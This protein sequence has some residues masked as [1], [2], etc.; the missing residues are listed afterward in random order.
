MAHWK[1]TV[2]SNSS[3]NGVR[4]EKT[5]FVEMVTTCLSN[6]IN[7]NPGTNRPLIGNLFLNKYGVDLYKAGVITPNY[8]Q[9]ERIS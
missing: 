8:I 3:V 2:K 9:A 6:P 7:T 1:F 4:L 5:M